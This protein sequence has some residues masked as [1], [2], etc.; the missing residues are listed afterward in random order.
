MIYYVEG[1][2]FE[3]PAQTLI[4]TVNTVGAMGKGIA[5]S[6]KRHFPAMFKEYQLQCESGDAKIGKLLIHRTPH[7]WVLNFPTKE[8]WRQP[9]KLA[10]IRLGLQT[11]VESYEAARISSVAFPKLGCGNGELDWDDVKPLMEEYLKKL[12]IDVYIYVSKKSA[13]PEHRNLKEMKRWLMSE[14]YSYPFSEFW[15]NLTEQIARQSN[16]NSDVLDGWQV[17]I[18]DDLTRFVLNN[19]EFVIPKEGDESGV[20]WREIWQFVRSKGRCFSSD[21]QSMGI[22]NASPVLKILSQL[23]FVTRFIHVTEDSPLGVHLQPQSP[24][25][26]FFGSTSNIDQPEL[27]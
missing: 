4:N 3:S 23:P 26:D 1:D 7:K 24:N 13:S 9:S 12:P 18:V 11:F 2:L 25:L 16:S 8:H 14:P 10:Y 19:D 27:V 5:L 22:S 6:F 20:G 21:L 15:G 17:T